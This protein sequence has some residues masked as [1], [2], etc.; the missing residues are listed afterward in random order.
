MLSP[1]LFDIVELLVDRWAVNL[2]VGD[3]GAIVEQHSDRADEVAIPNPDS[4]TPHHSG[5]SPLPGRTPHH[6]HR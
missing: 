1:E 4:E 2:R 3:R 5:R 6:A